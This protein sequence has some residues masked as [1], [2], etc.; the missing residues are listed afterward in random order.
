MYNWNVQKLES[1]NILWTS[2]IT[3]FFNGKWKMS[4]KTLIFNSIMFSL[5][6]KK[7]LKW[8]SIHFTH[9]QLW[10]DERKTNHN[11]YP[12]QNF[13]SLT[14]SCR[15]KDRRTNRNV[16]CEF[17]FKFE[18]ETHYGCIDYIQVKNG[19]KIPG[20]PWCSTKV[21]GS[22]R[23]HVQ[24]GRHFGNCD[25]SCPSAEEGLRQHQ[26]SQN[27]SSSSAVQATGKWC[28]DIL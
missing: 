4:L 1:A 15:V 20:K 28:F 25:D 6:T 9:F 24:G 2:L 3:R 12:F 14:E 17:P 13:V 26:Q 7:K 8:N 11:L 21:S 16:P 10:K 18:G 5:S 22:Q 27:R 19:R 23:E